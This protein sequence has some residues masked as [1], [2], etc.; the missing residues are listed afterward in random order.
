[1]KLLIIG[2]GRMGIRHCTGALGAAKLTEICLC[3][4][5]EQSLENA[6]QQLSSLDKDKKLVYTLS[7][8]VKGVYNIVIIASTAKD[9]LATCRAALETSPQYILIEKPL[10][11]SWEEVVQLDN[12]FKTAKVA[13]SV[14]LNMTMYPLFKQ[15]RNDLKS[16]PQMKGIKSIN[17]QGG[18]LGIGAN[19]IHYLDLLF[20][21][22]DAERGELV[23]GEI[24]PEIIPSGRGS[25]FADFGGWACFKFYD[26]TDN[27][28]GRSLFSLSAISTV[29]GGWDI[30]GMHG[31]IR[32]NELEGE[33]VDILRKPESLLPI[34]RYA[35]D[36]LP[37][38][39]STISS[40]SLSDLTKEWITG[41]CEKGENSLPS[42]DHSLKIHRLMFDWL[43]LSKTHNKIF[44]I[45]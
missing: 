25:Q 3:D 24:D 15:L 28:L 10:G 2:A 23:S 44:P 37:A 14:N 29:F 30:V 7:G 22:F 8:K 40:P 13:A 1:M 6:K 16:F 20:Y 42:I 26:R 4:I 19:G 38:S 41:I 35:G 21:L 45:T 5:S 31:R 32:I 43:A 11:Q 36:Y 17:S 39:V 9:R 34:N 33:R 12:F 18:T 27:Y